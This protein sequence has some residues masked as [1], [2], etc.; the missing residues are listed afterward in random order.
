MPTQ[1]Q[2]IMVT[3]IRTKV[4]KPGE[5]GKTIAVGGT[6]K[7]GAKNPVANVIMTI[8]VLSAQ[9]GTMGFSIAGKGI[10]I[11]GRVTNIRVDPVHPGRVQRNKKK[12]I[13]ICK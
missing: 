13:Y 6:I 4:D 5:I 10:R 12:Y 9:V 11:E 2:T 1:G 7:T 8:D 3:I